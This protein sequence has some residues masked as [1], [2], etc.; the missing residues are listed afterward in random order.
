MAQGIEGGLD[1]VSDLPRAPRHYSV[2]GGYLSFESS[3]QLTLSRCL[4]R[5]ERPLHTLKLV[6]FAEREQERV[7]THHLP[8]R[9]SR[10]GLCRR[11]LARTLRDQN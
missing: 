4:G 6:D 3:P 11:A 1:Q 8:V 9:T 2:W 10:R 7:S 5:C